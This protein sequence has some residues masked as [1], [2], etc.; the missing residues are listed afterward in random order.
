MTNGALVQNA[1]PEG[2]HEPTHLRSI[3]TRVINLCETR[4]SSVPWSGQTEWH[5]GISTEFGVHAGLDT[6]F[7]SFLAPG[8]G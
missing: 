1:D 3:I 8:F 4:D 5:C 6:R 7:C 2:S